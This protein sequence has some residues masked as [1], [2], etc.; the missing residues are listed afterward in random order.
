MNIP[1]RSARRAAVI[2]RLAALLAAFIPAAASAELL[3]AP[4]RIV[5]TPA[6]RSA[7]LILVNKGSEAAAFRLALENRRMRA[8]GGLEAAAEALPGEAFAADKLRFSPRQL[9]LEPG[10]RQVVRIMAD[11]PAGLAAGEYRSHLRLMSAPVSA[12]RN[13]P[14]AGDRPDNSLSIELIAIR[15]ITVP[16]ILRI[17]TLAALPAHLP[18]AISHDPG[19]Q[20]LLLEAR[21]P[22]PVLMRLHRAERQARLRPEAARPAYPLLPREPASARLWSVDVA[23]GLDRSAGRSDATLLAQASGELFGLAARGAIGLAARAPFQLGLT[24]SAAHD[25][26]DLLGP[27][28]AR[29]LAIGDIATP[30]QPLIADALSGRGLVIASRPP[31]RADLV[32]MIELS[33]PLPPGWE[34][35]LW[36]DDRL[37]AA[38]RTADPTGLWRFAGLPVRLGENRW[39]V[40]L[41]GPYG[42]HDEQ[43]FTRLVGT[44]M[45][46]ENEVDYSI[47]FVD[48]GQPLWGPAPTRGRSAAA[49][50]ASLGWGLAP[51]LTARL[52]LH[53]AA[54]GDPALSLGLHGAHA[55]TLWAATVARDRAGSLGGALRLARRLAGAD[56]LFDAARHGRDAGPAQPPLVREFAS[57]ASLGGQG[58]LALGRFSLPWQ[59]RLQSAERRGGG[60]QQSV[61]AR[62]ALPFNG[63]Q[64][65]GSIGLVR[66]A[67]SGWQGN[68]ALGL[69]AGS[70]PWRLRAGLDAVLAAGWRLAGTTLSAARASRRG[71]VSLDLGWQPQRRQWS[72]ALSVNRRIGAFGLSAG[73]GRGGDGWRLAMGLVVGLW[74][75]GGRWQ[76]APAG[77]TRS[78]AVAADLFIDE[79]DDG[80][81]DPGEAAVAGGRFI[82][83]NS[84]RSETTGRDGVALLRAL[85][86]GAA[87]DLETQ[88]SS[89][90]DFTLRP[91]R[92]GDRVQLHPGEVRRIAVPLRRTGSID[93]Q[94][95]LVAGDERTPRAGV[96]VTLHDASG[97]QMASAVSDFD[98]HVLFDGLPLAGW[99]V[100]SA[101][102]SS[103][104]LSLSR[105]APDQAITLILP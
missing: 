69:A 37:V 57:L 43:L 87:F 18:L 59:V 95:L 51:S 62:L 68:A 9:V 14:V 47:G 64:A 11:T 56:L 30:A 25:A 32:D 76:A 46:A 7:E 27:L 29:S 73:L 3:V 89:L 24:L 61:S 33:G 1:N 53:A 78:G 63:V 23:A 50:F 98:G 75:A 92:A 15:S 82:V 31:W 84:V 17:G 67:G 80:R 96:T 104:P 77:L 34:A 38:T 74:Q 102:Q 10:A 6:T 94:M 21:A 5:L 99:S 13:T 60:G 19:S 2:A 26:P 54:V 20:R 40:R 44:E 22:L 79:D 42:E 85:P 45:N 88:L 16:V 83:A 28:G 65:N 70:G 58:R 97:R 90:D 41:H 71:T 81:H 100:R 101:G 86:A 72:G 66:Q 36:H 4:T 52:A 103:P 48:A 35:E 49:G 39:V 8:D 105:D 91:A 93:A 12:G 55:G